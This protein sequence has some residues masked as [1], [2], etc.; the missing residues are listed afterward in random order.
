MEVVR[1]LVESGR[2]GLAFA[3][4]CVFLVPV[5]IV[6]VVV[7]SLAATNDLVPLLLP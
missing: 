6:S 3:S 2:P 1:L 4:V 5:A 7:F